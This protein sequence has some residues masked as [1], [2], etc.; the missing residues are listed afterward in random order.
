MPHILP[1]LTFLSVDSATRTRRSLSGG[2]APRGYQPPPQVLFLRPRRR[3][4]GVVEGG[5]RRT[6]PRVQ[7]ESRSKH[8]SAR[9]EVQLRHPQAV[10]KRPVHVEGSVGPPRISLA[11][12]DP[13]PGNRERARATARMRWPS[14]VP[15]RTRHPGRRARGEDGPKPAA[16]RPWPNHGRPRGS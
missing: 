9:P 12:P 11:A 3:W 7:D 5:C 13:P 14:P 4:H 10:G 16:A 2:S 8:L 6:V 1:F 15:A